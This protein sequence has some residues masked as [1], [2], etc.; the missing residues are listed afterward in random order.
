MMHD[1]GRRE[2][3]YA[4]AGAPPPS[5][6][7]HLADHLE[8]LWRFRWLLLVGPLLAGAV[9]YG[10]ALTLTPEFLA[11][12]TLIVTPSK[13]G[14][15][16]TS[17]PPPDVR[18]YRAFLQNQSLAA[19]VVREFHLNAAPASLTPQRFLD[20]HVNVQEV[21]GTNLVSL[22][23]TL[24][25]AQ[26]A[27]RVAN[28]M[29]ERAVTLSRSLEQREAVVA[30]DII[31][32]QLDAARERLTQARGAL[33]TYQRGAQV[34]LLEKKMDV[35]MNQQAE[36]QQ[37]AVDI[38]GERAYLQQAEQDLT[39][40]EPVRSAQRSVQVAPVGRPDPPVTRPR[41]AS[42]ADGRQGSTI[43]PAG[44]RLGSKRADSPREPGSPAD[45]T[46]P[47]PLHPRLRDDLIDPYINPAYEMLQQDVMAV[48]SRLAQLEYKRD[49]MLKSRAK[50]GQLA[51]LAEYYTRKTAENE[52]K[53][54][55]DLAEK[56][57]LDVAT[58]Y[59]QARLQIA[60]RSA[61][62]QVVDAALPPDRKEYPREKL[63]ASAAIVLA[64]SLL[65]AAI[66]GSTA[67]TRL[68]RQAVAVRDARS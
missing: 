53:M 65:A 45:T 1:T 30:R 14:D 61:Q 3:S 68:R 20:R 57:Y 42:L 7:L 22:E 48:R 23:V 8:R 34:D 36:L 46:P 64:F 67:V 43:K 35:L 17:S 40:L 12:A 51:G 26:I 41:V 15:Q 55:Q 52:L 18:N 5:D 4:A 38:K 31:K 33:A 27:A 60:S 28:A 29:A 2:P 58:R 25:E 10:V 9:A 54:Q 47:L 56:I 24:N 66:V 39:Q 44:E 16:T 49:E 13:A 37:L 59:E 32:S 11:V 50:D 19:E 6:A 62:L 21:R 63:I